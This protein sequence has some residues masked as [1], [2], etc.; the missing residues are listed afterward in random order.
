MNPAQQLPSWNSHYCWSTRVCIHTSTHMH[1][2]PHTSEH[3]DRRTRAHT[4]THTHMHACPHI[5]SGIQ[6]RAQV[7]GNQE[8]HVRNPASPILYPMLS[9]ASRGFQTQMSPGAW[10]VSSV[11]AGA[12]MESSRG[13]GKLWLRVCL[14]CHHLCR[15]TART[16]RI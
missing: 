11:S 14:P 12:W 15:R 8:I 2:H 4:E 6:S 9:S 7:G 16:L 13:W 10:Q 5:H 1:M 3:T